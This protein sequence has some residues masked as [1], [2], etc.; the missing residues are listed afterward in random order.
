VDR[1]DSCSFVYADLPV[2]DIAAR[3]RLLAAQY[4]DRLALV[5]DPS[6][7]AR[8]EPETWSALEYTCHVR[9]VFRVQR[10]R[11]A[12]TLTVEVPEYVPMGRDE[13]VVDDHYN[14][15]VLTIVLA[16]LVVAADDLATAFEALDDDQWLRTGIYNWP[17]RA[18]RSL[19]WLGRHTT[20]EAMHH[21][22]DIDR[23][24]DVVGA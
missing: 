5:D 11:V 12:L 24:L 18:E 9:D 19:E 20:H 2:P 15:Q 22:R 8:P 6:L 16:D 4:P 21:L 1:C 17:E 10:E 13:R 7:R 23:G 14:E 3:L